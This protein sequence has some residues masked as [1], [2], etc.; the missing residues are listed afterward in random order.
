MN[1]RY[2]QQGVV[3][4]TSLILLIIMTLMGVSML[5]TSMIELKIGGANQLT[6][7]TLANAEVAIISYVNE[8]NY[9]AVNWAAAGNGILNVG[10]DTVAIAP[11]KI[12]C[13]PPGTRNSGDQMA[14][15][16]NP[17]SAKVHYNLNATATSVFGAKAVVN[18][19]I[20]VEQASCG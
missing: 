9:G 6:A 13:T 18:Q 19:G 14:D 7:Q 15:A 20:T 5:K 1:T 11:T 12:A 2:H 8:R 16:G 10:A 3:L 4:I 17:Y